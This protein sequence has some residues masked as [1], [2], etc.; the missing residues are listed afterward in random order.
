MYKIVI[1]INLNL[2]FQF[3]LK[4]YTFDLNYINI[5]QL[6]KSVLIKCIF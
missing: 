2:V 3:S 1:Q 5:F 4:I 6:F